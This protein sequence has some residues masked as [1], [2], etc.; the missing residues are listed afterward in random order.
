MNPD[1]GQ[2]EA[3]VVEA[4]R[5]ELLPR[6][7]RVSVERKSD[8][9]PVTE[10]DLAVHTRLCEALRDRWPETAF[11]SEEM[12]QSEQEALLAAGG[13]LWVLDPLDGTSNFVAGVP[14]FCLS[15]AYLEGGEVQLGLVY[16]PLRQELFRA[17][18]GL[19]AYLNDVPL[20]STGPVVP[21]RHGIVMVDFKRLPQALRRRLVEHPPYASQRNFGAGALEWAWL[22]AGRGHAYVH[23]GQKLWDYA[24]GSLILAEAGGFSS[25]LDGDAVYKATVA[26]RSV[27]AARSRDVFNEWYAWLT[28]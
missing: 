11:L 5:E 28:A 8:A 25:T 23:G 16:D 24:A 7:A 6:F 19:G 10:A 26:S 18:R 9:S 15:L 4:A 22:A 1:I 14:H 13:P 12:P 3:L 2:L 27:V 20:R 17:E 21:L